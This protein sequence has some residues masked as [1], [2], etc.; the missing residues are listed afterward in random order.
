M[1]REFMGR[2][3]E[4]LWEESSLKIYKRRHRD[5]ELHSFATCN[6]GDFTRSEFDR[7]VL[8]LETIAF[9]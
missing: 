5:Y 8:A 7:L 4:G 6:P 1:G 9:L 2:E 3:Q